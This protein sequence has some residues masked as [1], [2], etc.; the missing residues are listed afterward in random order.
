LVVCPDGI[1]QDTVYEFKATNKQYFI[2]FTKPVALTQADIYGHFFG[3]KKKRVQIYVRN[4]DRIDTFDLPVEASRVRETLDKF[5]GA[6]KG[7][8]PRPPAKFKCVKCEYREECPMC[9]C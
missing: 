9:Q 4:S 2:G 3:K 7:E 8:R 6:A 5:I 1:T